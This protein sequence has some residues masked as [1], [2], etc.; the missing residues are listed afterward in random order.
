[1]KVT[2]RSAVEWRMDCGPEANSSW[3]RLG[4]PGV[5]DEELNYGIVGQEAD[6]KTAG[7]SLEK[8]ATLCLGR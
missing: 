6:G 8:S 2:K 7:E 3:E 1:M 5:R 4:F